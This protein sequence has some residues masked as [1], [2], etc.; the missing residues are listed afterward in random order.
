MTEFYARE[1]ANVHR[2]AHYLSDRATVKFEEARKT[3]AQFVGANSPQE[4]IFTKGTTDSINLVASSWGRRFLNSGDEIILSEMEHH[5][6][7][8]PWQ[9]IAEERGCKVRF[10]RVTPEGELDFDHFLTLLNKNTKMLAITHC[11]NTLGTLND[12]ARF[13]REAQRV[14]VK[15]LVD[16]AQSVTF[17]RLDVQSLGCDFLVFSGHKIY[18][19]Y[20]VGVLF[21]RQELLAEMPPYQGGGA[22]IA[23]VTQEKTTYLA[24]PQRFEAG[25]PNISGVIGLGAAIKFTMGL[26]PKSVTAHE[27]GLLSRAVR[28]LSNFER[29][30]PV[31]ISKSRVNIFSFLLKGLHPADVGQILD[32]QGVAV[33][34][35]HH[36]TQPLMRAYGL[37][38][39]VRASFGVY[40][41][42]ED[43]DI[44]V[45]ALKKAQ[46]LLA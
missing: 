45:R 32:Q 34:I 39:T 29:F 2:G 40:N 27:Q 44:F 12:L 17:C 30:Q 24:P 13:L 5:S 28:E 36:C 16:A 41:N 4:I 1:T 20:G 8:V 11:S 19:P 6:N 25:T 15:T 31:G 46:E 38:G 7:I 10:I 43:V 14:G 35:G 37:T 3:V 23:Q 22:M 33:R 18:G 21:G 9:M 26:D 42:E